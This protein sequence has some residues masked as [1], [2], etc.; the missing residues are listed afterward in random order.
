M[1]LRTLSVAALGALQLAFFL[2][3]PAV[4]VDEV[5]T[6]GD[7]LR[8]SPSPDRALVYLLHSG[9]K[10]MDVLLDRTP[11][12]RLKGSYL[13]VWADPGP[14]VVWGTERPQRFDFEPGKRYVLTFLAGWSL[15]RTD[16]AARPVERLKLQHAPPTAKQ[17]AEI[18]ERVTEGDYPWTLPV[19]GAAL[20]ARFESVLFKAAKPGPFRGLE[21]STPGALTVDRNTLTYQK[22]RDSFHIS[23]AE[24]REAGPVPKK[25]A[26]LRVV[27]GRAE[28]PDE[29]FFDLLARDLPRARAALSAARLAS[30]GTERA[31]SPPP[32]DAAQG[33]LLER[34][35][36][37][38]DALEARE[39]AGREPAWS[40][41][42]GARL[43]LE[44][45]SEDVLDLVAYF[46]VGEY[47]LASKLRAPG[48]TV[49]LASV[50]IGG[51][52][53]GVGLVY[54]PKALNAEAPGLLPASIVPPE[55]AVLAGDPALAEV[56]AVLRELEAHLE[57]APPDAQALVLAARLG[58]LAEVARPLPAEA[59]LLDWIQ[60]ETGS[61]ERTTRLHGLVAKALALRPGD[62]AALL[63][64][65]R[66]A[67][68]PR[69]TAQAERISFTRDLDQ[70]AGSSRLALER[71]PGDPTAL[72]L[73]ATSLAGAGKPDEALALLRQESQDPP[74]EH[75]LA[76]LAAVPVP[77]GAAASQADSQRLA[78]LLAEKGWFDSH[79]ELRVRSF[80]VP[81]GAE[82]V[83]D[84]YRRL[85]PGSDFF[86][87]GEQALGTM[88]GHLRGQHLRWDAERGLRPT[89]SK[90]NLESGRP[91]IVLF[92]LE[93]S[94]VPPEAAKLMP[95]AKALPKPPGK[96][97]CILSVVTMRGFA[98]G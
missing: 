10:S 70:A 43:P 14:R 75:L 37:L 19:L 3:S 83:L 91:G 59:S 44:A 36:R 7:P 48:M 30:G 55:T 51:A 94:A 23:A 57:S 25:D 40:Q 11:L 95:A 47:E 92:L 68:M 89:G 71:S 29:V 18:R 22:G 93:L 52:A 50:P 65:A 1:S 62:P 79:R 15:S 60:L 35:A 72:A 77:E 54:R 34:A 74:I 76:D 80:A 84:F 46:E 4:A 24:I 90:K 45:V 78:H 28:P 96:R 6:E 27:Y 8:L 63:A 5:V 73:V 13:A 86:D 98:E 9:N 38:A 64:Q 49:P 53:I 42:P 17:L 20:P 66:L 88:T 61:Q 58:R 87:L 12:G 31:S 82:K 21:G 39:A 32:A 16:D 41:A 97:F 2:P 81:D 67:A 33:S 26:T 69:L 56:S 85:W